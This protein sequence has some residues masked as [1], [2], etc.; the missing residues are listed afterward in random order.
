MSHIREIHFAIHL[1][2]K[3]AAPTDVRAEQDG[4]DTVLVTW[5]PPSP[6]PAAGYQVQVTV[7]N[8][9]TTTNATG[10][11]HNISVNNQFGVYSIR[12]ISLPQHV[13]LPSVSEA[14]PAEVTVNGKSTANVRFLPVTA[15][16]C[17][18]GGGFGVVVIIIII[19]IGM[20][21]NRPLVAT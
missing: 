18:G 17:L 11:S 13:H 15:T 2:T 20:M 6:P 16:V 12:V 8:T 21:R 10:T 5:T 3:C 14:T 19:I 9:T 7:D 4:P 1:H